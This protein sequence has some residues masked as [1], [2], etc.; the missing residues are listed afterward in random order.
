MNRIR[1]AAEFTGF[2]K[3]QAAPA[4]K[5]VERHCLRDGSLSMRDRLSIEITIAQGILKGGLSGDEYRTFA[6]LCPSLVDLLANSFGVT[7][8]QLHDI[9]ACEGIDADALLSALATDTA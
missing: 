1:A 6:E 8:N 7:V 9:G 5:T 4:A 3:A 2:S